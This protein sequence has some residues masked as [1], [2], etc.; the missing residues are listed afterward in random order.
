MIP[1]D[2]EYGARSKLFW[3]SLRPTGGLKDSPGKVAYHTAV[4][5]KDCVYIFGGN[6]CENTHEVIDPENVE[7]STIY[8]LSLV[9][10]RWY[11]IKT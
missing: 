4:V 3:Q 5:F 11:N 1:E 7:N 8:Q 2:E 6:N 10:M 9:E